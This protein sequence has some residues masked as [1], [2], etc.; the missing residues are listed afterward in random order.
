MIDGLDQACARVNKIEALTVK[1]KNVDEP[2]GQLRD[3]PKEPASIEVP[4][5][6]FTFPEN[7]GQQVI[8]WHKQMVIEGINGQN[9]EKGGT[10]EYL[11][12]DLKEV[13]FKITFTNMGIFKLTPDKA[14]AQNETIRRL[15]AELYCEEMKFEYVNAAAIWS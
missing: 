9:M 3:Y 8:D 1:Q 13:I 15:K 6:V 2:V 7:N 14:E 5:L 10:L 12:P 11:T 4:N